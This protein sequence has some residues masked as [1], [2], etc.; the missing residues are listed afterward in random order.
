MIWALHGAVGT[1]ADWNQFAE[2]MATSGR[3][4][5][6]V[7]LWQF[8]EKE[9]CSIEEFGVRFCQRVRAEDQEPILLGYS[10]G[11]RLAL[12]ALLEDSAMWRAAVIVSAHPGLQD[13]EARVLRMA[14]DAHWAGRALVGSWDRFLQDWNAQGILK[15]EHPTAL[16]ERKGLE[17][18]RAALATGLMEWS[19]GKQDDLRPRLGEIGCPLL[20]LSGE[21]DSKFGALAAES[22]SLLSKGVHEIVRGVGHRVPWEASEDFSR[23]VGGFL[24]KLKRT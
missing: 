16:L 9:G 23:A 19:L 6:G 14:S 24:S 7:D 11:G 1:E 12:H 3:E 18:R 2:V 13:D 17:S 8:V 15:S 10:L 21:R 4:V 20:W 5:K 22:V